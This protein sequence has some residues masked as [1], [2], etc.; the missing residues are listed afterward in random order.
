[1]VISRI[2]SLVIEPFLKWISFIKFSDYNDFIATSQKDH[3]I[4]LLSEV[5]NVYR[6][7]IAM[8]MSILMLK[9]YDLLQIR[10]CIPQWISILI[11]LGGLLLIF[12]FSYRKQN[13]Y[14]SNRV[15]AIKRSNNL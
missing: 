2:G 1:M 9:A 12:I 8:F 11:L 14:V 7:L 10:C 5:N 13:Q 15:N 3:K 6:T 4:E